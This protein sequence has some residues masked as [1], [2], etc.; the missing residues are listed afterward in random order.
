M[1]MALGLSYLDSGGK[2]KSSIHWDLLKDMKHDGEV[3][4]DGKLFYKK[5][6]FLI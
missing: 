3:Y 5:G 6:K 1:H 4:A 2:N